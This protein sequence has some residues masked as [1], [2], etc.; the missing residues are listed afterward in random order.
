M[1]YHRL[2]VPYD[3]GLFYTRH[4]EVH[5]AV[6]GPGADAPAYLATSSTSNVPSPLNV[7][8]EN[9]SR[10]RGLPLY[11][12]LV[13]YGIAGYTSIIRRNI[14]FARKLEKWIR[15]NDDYDILTPDPLGSSFRVLNI[16]L[17]APS[18]TCPVMEFRNDEN[19]G[20]R[21]TEEIHK[22]GE[23]YV[24]ATKWK[25]RSAARLAVSNHLTGTLDGGDGDF[26]IVTG[27]L[28]AIM[29]KK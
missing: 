27:R 21:M 10:F 18:Q 15:E 6:C 22:S 26:E 29:E 13:N 14:E 7:R 11:A 1:G 12:S 28:K 3:C 20:N 5:Q 9:S 24:T 2:N 4:P 16:V 17:F 23:M 25:G 19:G 8:L